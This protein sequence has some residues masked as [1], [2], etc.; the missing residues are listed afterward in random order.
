MSKVVKI[1]VKNSEGLY[2]NL[3]PQSASS[4]EYGTYASLD[5][6]KGTIEER[7][8][9][10]GFKSGSATL[11]SQYEVVTTQNELKRQGNYVLGRIVISSTTIHNLNFMRHLVATLPEEFRPKEDFTFPFMDSN[12][13]SFSSATGDNTITASCT[14]YA[15]NGEVWLTRASS[16]GSGFQGSMS[17]RTNLPFKL[18]FGYEANPL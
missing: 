6:S 12:Y 11:N 5:K 10:L 17:E 16:T 8:T 2:D 9:A 7:L 18:Y 3:I 1:K 15:E 4:A 14:I 13:T